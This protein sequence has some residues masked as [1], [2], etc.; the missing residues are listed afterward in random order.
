[1]KRLSV[2]QNKTFANHLNKEKGGPKTALPELNR[3]AQMYDPE[4]SYIISIP[5]IQRA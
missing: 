5:P 1:V 3:M 2:L 4:S